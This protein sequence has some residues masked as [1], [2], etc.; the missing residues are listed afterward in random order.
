MLQQQILGALGANRLKGR[1]CEPSGERGRGVRGVFDARGVSG[2]F[3]YDAMRPTASGALRDAAERGSASIVSLR[4]GTRARSRTSSLGQLRCGLVL[5]HPSE[6]RCLSVSRSDAS[7]IS[8]WQC[9]LRQPLEYL[10]L[11]Q[12]ARATLSF[13]FPPPLA[14]Y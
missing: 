10:R 3:A 11:E 6:W 9:S 8:G 7:G 14:L 5:K 12:L 1:P 4:V 2:Q 13:G